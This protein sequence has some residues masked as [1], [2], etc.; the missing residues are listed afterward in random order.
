MEEVIDARKLIKIYGRGKR[1]VEAVRG[2]DLKVRHGEIFG[3]VGPDGAGKT[4]TIQMLCGIL[5]PTSGSASVAGVDVTRNAEALGGKIGYM[6]EGFTLYGTLSVEENLDFFAELYHVPPAVAAERKQE[7]LRFA[8]L[9]EARGRRAEQLSGGM[10]KKLALACTLIYRPEVLFLDEPTTGV[11]PVS[12][13]DFWKILY[14]FLAEGIT[15]FMT[16]PYMDEA[17]RCNRVALIRRGQIIADDAP[18]ALK[19]TLQGAA[20]ELSAQPQPQAVTYLRQLSSVTQMQVF[21]ERLHLLLRD[22]PAA[23]QNLMAQ[24]AAAGVSVTDFKSASPSLEDVF[25]AAVDEQRAEAERQRPV[26]VLAVA[27]RED[28]RVALVEVDGQLHEVLH[29]LE[30]L[31]VAVEADEADAG[32]RDER[33][34]AV[35]HP[36]PGAQHR[37]DRDLLAV[38]PLRGHPLERRLD[39]PR[40]GLHVLRR[41]VGQ[42]ERD[43]VRELAEE[44]GRGLPVA[45]VRE[46]VLD[47]RVLDDR[48]TPA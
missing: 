22:G 16:T 38:D 18:S 7:L 19:Q 29:R 24:L 44:D 31:L 45:Q 1:R 3:L 4:T 6:S 2:I 13:Q 48:Q 27:D 33:E 43:L 17:E 41:L 28:D 20:I 32:A 8:R 34:D 26:G 21:G 11:D 25:I 15:I 42:E 23:T 35:E 14:E 47:E 12:R 10:K 30:G 9:E 46:L 37:T 39:L 40:L 36:H 5:S